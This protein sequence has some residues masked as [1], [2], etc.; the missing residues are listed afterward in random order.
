[1]R[2]RFA[3]VVL[4]VF[5]ATNLFAKEVFL[6]VSGTANGVFFSDARIFN[7]NDKEITVSAYYLPRGNESNAGGQPVQIKVAKREM[8]VLDDIVQNTLSAGGV[9]GIRLVSADDFIA[10]QRVYALVRNTADAKPCGTSPDPCTLGQFVQGQDISKAIK[11]GAILQLKKSAAFRTNIG[12]ANPNNA[13]ARVTWR[14]YDKNNALIASSPSPVQMPPYAVIGPT[15]IDSDFFYGS[16]VSAAAN[17]SDAW[18]GFTSDQPIFAYGSVVDNASTDQTYVPA[19]ED[20]GVVPVTPQEKIVTIT[21]QDF[22]FNVT[23]NAALKQGDTVKFRISG[24]GTHGIWITTPNGD[25]IVKQDS[26]TP[27]VVE[28]T[29]TLPAGVSGQYQFFCT[30]TLCG[31]GHFDMNGTLTVGASASDPAGAT[32]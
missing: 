6:A 21:A 4:L 13:T 24:T 1:M 14:L 29:R 17:L 27:T 31:S 2:A 8:K 18:V 12:A 28:L 9:G 16:P 32:R 20:S 30:N 26:I 25:T 23:T 15:A 10:T 11:Q 5:F 22:F 3:L 19:S 7:P